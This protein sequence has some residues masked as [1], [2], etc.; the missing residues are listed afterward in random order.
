M[1]SLTVALQKLLHQTAEKS[2]TYEDEIWIL[3]FSRL[4]RKPEHSL[5]VISAALWVVLCSHEWFEM[6]FCSAWSHWCLHREEVNIAARSDTVYL[7]LW[8]S[9]QTVIT[10]VCSHVHDVYDDVKTRSFSPSVWIWMASSAWASL[11]CLRLFTEENDVPHWS[12]TCFL[13]PLWSTSW[14]FNALGVGKPLPH[15]L[16]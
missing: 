5:P 11:C 4:N 3:L 14:R 13:A 7:W 10:G 1:N 12:Q 9:S 2:K 15:S 8:H 16:Q 6:I